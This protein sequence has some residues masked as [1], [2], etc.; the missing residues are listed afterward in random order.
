MKTN[1]SIIHLAGS[2]LILAFT[3]T[4]P[5]G[6]LAQEQEGAANRIENIDF[7]A[8]PGGRNFH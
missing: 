3:A 4:F 6:A 5:G 8:L 7:A 1:A 2:L